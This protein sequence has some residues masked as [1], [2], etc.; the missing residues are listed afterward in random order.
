MS[1]LVI[2]LLIY[3]PCRAPKTLCIEQNQPLVY[4]NRNTKTDTRVRSN[5]HAKCFAFEYSNRNPNSCSTPSTQLWNTNCQ[6]LHEQHGCV[7]VC[8]QRG[9]NLWKQMLVRA[10]RLDV[11][12]RNEYYPKQQNHGW[13]FMNYLSIRQNAVKFRLVKTCFLCRSS[14]YT[15]ILFIRRFLYSFT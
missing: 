12:R 6:L 7:C 5:L 11:W 8:C 3:Q 14:L 4:L 15:I 9:L 1:I 10:R 13:A 2:G